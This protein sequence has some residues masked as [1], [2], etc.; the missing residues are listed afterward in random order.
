[1]IMNLTVKVERQ[2]LLICVLIM[3][4]MLEIHILKFVLFNKI[5]QVNHFIVLWCFN[6]LNERLSN[7]SNIWPSNFDDQK[8]AV[9]KQLSWSPKLD[10][11]QGNNLVIWIVYWSNYDYFWPFTFLQITTQSKTRLFTFR[12]IQLHS[13]GSSTLELTHF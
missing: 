1:M 4:I 6:S 11:S 8:T 3:I 9:T 10:S 5:L 7:M 2:C 12:T 13:L